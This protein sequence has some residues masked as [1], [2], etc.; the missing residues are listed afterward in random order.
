MKKLFLT[1]TFIFGLFTINAQRA[2]SIYAEIL[3]N[4]L[5]YSVNYDVRFANVDNQF[6]I[7]L[8]AAYFVEAAY[9]IV[10]P[11]YL[12]GEDKHKLELGAGFTTLLEFGNGANENQLAA[13][14][15]IMYRFQNPEGNFLF[16]AGLAPTFV[17]IDEDD[18]FSGLSRLFW[19]WPGVSFGYKF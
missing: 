11:N 5:F 19:I 9:L 18:T 3:G 16:Q 4:G 1:L 6:G 12:F 15:S 10:Q 17:P 7:R 2:Q 8:G 14:A 13:N